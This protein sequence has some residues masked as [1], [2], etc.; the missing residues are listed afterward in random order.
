MEIT[1]RT[2]VGGDLEAPISARGGTATASYVLVPAVRSGDV[3]VHYD[4]SREAIVGASLAVG[5]PEPSTTFWVARG[6]SARR[7]GA[8]PQWLPGIRVP[9]N[10]YI[11][12]DPELTLDELRRHEP[13]LMA[14]RAALSS[15]HGA[16]RLYFPW[17]P[18]RG[19][20]MRTFQSY[21]VKLPQAAIDVVPR[22]RTLV[23]SAD[24][25]RQGPLTP[26]PEAAVIEDAVGAAAARRRAGRGQSYQLDQQVKVAVEAHA[27]NLAIEFYEKSWIVEDVHGSESFDLRCTRGD[28]ELHVEVKGT[29]TDGAE[30]LLTPNEVAHARSHPDVALFVVIRIHIERH[31]D[32]RVTASGGRK[33]VFHP[34]DIDAGDLVPVGYK[35]RLP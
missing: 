16:Q 32:G 27:M 26:R 22:L 11:D 25:A 18:Y 4:S 19:Q 29:T 20:R 13:K 7:A 6:T 30:V 9:L 10:H 28:T 34:W 17:V 14:V 2:D 15:R 5:D 23:D 33:V 3:V 8:A 35:Y 12:L 1:R 24:K 21:L 31:D